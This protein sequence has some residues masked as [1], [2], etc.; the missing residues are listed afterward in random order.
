VQ[1]VRAELHVLYVLLY[2]MMKTGDKRYL[3]DGVYAKFDC[4]A[5]IL[6]TEDGT[7]EIFIEME[8][9]QV[10]TNLLLELGVC[11]LRPDGHVYTIDEHDNPHHCAYCGTKPATSPFGGKFEPM[12]DQNCKLGSDVK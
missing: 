7:N 6:T 8:V 5:L 10:L 4:A 12:S 2:A 1:K 3:G 9:A 11:P